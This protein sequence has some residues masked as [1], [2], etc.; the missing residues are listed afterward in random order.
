MRLVLVFFGHWGGGGGRGL[1][2]SGFV[3][4]FFSPP[5]PCLVAFKENGRNRDGWKWGPLFLGVGTLRHLCVC[6]ALRRTGRKDKRFF[7]FRGEEDT[8]NWA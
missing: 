5:P 3:F 8:P 7:L 2:A 6:V 1:G 4:V